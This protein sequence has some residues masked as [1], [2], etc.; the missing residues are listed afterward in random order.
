MKLDFSSKDVSQIEEKGL[1]LEEVERQISIFKRGNIVVNVLEAATVKNGIDLYSDEE[2]EG[3]I[4]FYEA[5]RNR[6]D[7]LKFV[8]A[9]G[10]AT[11]MFKVFYRF[12]DEYD[13]G[14]ETVESFVER[15]NDSKL[16]Q[17]FLSMKTLPF[18][19]LVKKK[20]LE[21][22]SDYDELSE[23]QQQQIFVEAMLLEK[24]IDLGNYPKGL[25]PF[26]DYKD[27]VATAFE[28]HLTE[29][30]DYATSNGVA[31]LH[32]TVGRE[33]HQ[34]FEE[35]L[36]RIRQRVERENKVRFEV[37]FSY[38]DP[39]S[40]TLAVD[41]S[42]EPFRDD[43][44]NLFFRPGGH[45]ALLQN[46]ND[47]NADLI[48]I[49]NIDNVVIPK[50]REVVARNKRT[51]A[52]K[53]LQLQERTFRYLEKL[54]EMDVSEEEL[55]EIIR[56]VQKDLN[57][58]LSISFE[59]LSR[60]EKIA[61]LTRKM[62]R[63]IRVCGMVT[64]EGEP[65]GG[66]FWVIHKTGEISLQIVESSQIDHENYQQSKIAQEATHFNPVDVI[67]GIKNYKGKIFDLQKF[68]DNDTSF[69]SR[70]T[71]DG[72]ELKALEHPGLWNGAMAEWITVFVE[73]P[74]ETF[75]PVKTVA[76]LLKPTHQVR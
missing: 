11:R 34:K 64:N 48:F 57:S 50:Y 31:K 44:G 67:C 74:V 14:E 33:H 68:T 26:H 29:A 36:E 15:K 41:P 53:L 5:R 65:G 6:L 70:K 59:E 28:E 69:I 49:K 23:D 42:N 40:D 4:E 25:V 72:Q 18:Y 22:N 38:Q 56:F 21:N 66:P 46:L 63:P 32:F 43:D 27:H 62:H 7:L 16:E 71:K 24:G 2:M 17:F 52:G 3:F 76:D 37:S 51:L 13:P 47:Q 19:N 55:N 61:A 8:P 75:N 58:G 30:A 45:G 60:S 10:A 20:I 54:D 12:L 35:E 9:S 1:K 39:K 73:V